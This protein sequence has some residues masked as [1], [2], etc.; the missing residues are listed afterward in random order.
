MVKA[1]RNRIIHHTI[2]Q[3]LWVT[4]FRNLPL[5]GFLK[6]ITL[7]DIEWFQ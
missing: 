5:K 1:L 6:D 2:D 7:G 3:I 4:D